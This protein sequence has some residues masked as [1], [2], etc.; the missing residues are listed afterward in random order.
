MFELFSQFE[1]I[2]TGTK[3]IDVDINVEKNIPLITYHNGYEKEHLEIGNITAGSAMYRAGAPDI[4]EAYN[5]PTTLIDPETE[6]N[7]KIGASVLCMFSTG[8]L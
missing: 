5:I 8:S 3:S 7:T 2:G 1:G 4:V 6:E